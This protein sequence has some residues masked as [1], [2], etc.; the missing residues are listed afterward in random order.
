MGQKIRLGIMAS[1]GGSNA[2]SIL[3]NC[4]EGKLNAVGG[5]IISNN[6][7]AGVHEV[8]KQFDIPSAT[9]N[10][11]DYGKGSDFSRTLIESFMAAGV[12]LVCLA[13][14]M[15]KVPKAL[16][17][18]YPNAVINIHPALL[19]KHGGKGMYGIHV[20]EDVLKCG[21]NESGVTIHF[22]DAEYD[23]GP[24]LLQRG[25]VPVLDDDT[26]KSLAKR[27]LKLE[28]ELYPEAVGKWIKE[29]NS[30]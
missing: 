16:L 17:N 3:K 20:H 18:A 28:H 11:Q 4:A 1:G 19:P 7:D 2:K 23:R 29:Y 27:V 30:K 26:P 5:L 24:I 12:N 15:R 14:Y 21:D 8:A 13:G 10:R 9:I 25:G 22:V 6:L